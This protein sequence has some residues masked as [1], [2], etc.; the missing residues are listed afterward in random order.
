VAITSASEMIASPQ[1]LRY[2]W[3]FG[4]DAMAAGYDHDHLT[5]VVRAAMCKKHNATLATCG[6]QAATLRTL[7][8][9]LERADMGFTYTEAKATAQRVLRQTPEGVERNRLACAR[10]RA[11]SRYTRP[12]RARKAYGE[13][14]W[15]LL[16]PNKPNTTA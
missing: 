5:N 13:Q 6:D 8:D 16:S 10:W 12:S 11:S 14:L 2:M 9:W 7:A 4:C 3:P 1:T 15:A